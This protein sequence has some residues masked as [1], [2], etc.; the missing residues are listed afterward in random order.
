MRILLGLLI[1]LIGISRIYLGVH[2][3]SDVL[4]G[5]C[6]GLSWLLL[7][8]PYYLEK[9][10]V[11]RFQQNNLRKRKEGK[12][13]EFIPYAENQHKRYHSWNYALRQEFGEKYLKYRSMLASTVP[14]E[15]V[16]LQRWLYLL[17]RIWF[18]RHD[19]CT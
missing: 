18:R 2:F 12:I 7:T 6:V 14:I 1:F 13:H 16:L 4:G 8:Y 5:F 19:R 9:R 10:F 11:W 3:P 17:Q 15:M